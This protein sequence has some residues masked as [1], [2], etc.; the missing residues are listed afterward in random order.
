M[1]TVAHVNADLENDMKIFRERQALVEAKIVNDL[2]Q[3]AFHTMRKI[4]VSAQI[5]HHS[6]VLVFNIKNE[7]IH[8][9]NC[10]AI[11]CMSTGHLKRCR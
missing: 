9:N 8:G 3:H 7:N 11:C 1:P 6:V 10:I 4:I 5:K 2:H